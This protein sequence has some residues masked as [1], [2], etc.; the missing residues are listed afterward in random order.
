MM[1]GAGG[2]WEGPL[3]CT[4]NQSADDGYSEK[5]HEDKIHKFG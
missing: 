3:T 5:S 1:Q 2:L 4:G